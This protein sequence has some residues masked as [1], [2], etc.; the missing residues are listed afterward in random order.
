MNRKEFGQLVAALRKE[1]FDEDG[2]R[3]TQAGL[4]AR[5][6]RQDPHT[7]LNEIIIGKIERGERSILDEKTLLALADALSLMVGERRVFFV[8]ATG[9]DA[10]QIYPTPQ[11]S[12][13]ILQNTL[14]ILGDIQ[15]PALLLDTYLDI[16]GVNTA[17][18]H[19][20]NTSPT[21]INKVTTGNQA[22]N[23]LDF[24]FS[25]DFAPNRQHLS[26]EQWHDFATGN[27]M[28]FRRL[29]LPFRMTAYFQKLLKR[30]RRYRD[31]RYFWEQVFYEDSQFF[32]GGTSWQASSAESGRLHFLTAPLVTRTPYGNLELLTHIPR[33]PTT[34]AAFQQFAANNRSLQLA[35]WPDKP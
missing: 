9:L 32:V 20:Y 2:N 19:L 34:A 17:V 35:P 8:A 22:I 21:V 1:Q 29:T 3:L 14:E 7:S 13:T 15:L 26:Q 24:V 25:P 12:Q 33:S 10:D 18:L 4:A 11:E 30:L 28:Y 5:A 27:V 6:A 23:L 31:F 16:I